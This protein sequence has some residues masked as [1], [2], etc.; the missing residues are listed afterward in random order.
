MLVGVGV[1]VCIVGGVLMCQ[2][3]LVCEFV[4]TVAVC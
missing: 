2:N 4:Y 1:C 3:V